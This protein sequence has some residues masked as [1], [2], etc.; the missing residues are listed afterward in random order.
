MIFLT[1]AFEILTLAARRRRLSFLFLAVAAALPLRAQ[2]T[3]KP[4]LIA[5]AADLKFALDEVLAEFRKAHPE[6]DPKPTYGSSGT[7][8]AQID[9]GAPFDLFLS[10]DVKFPR[11]LIE[12]A[13][14]EKDSLF[15]YAIG[16]VVVWVPKESKLDLT[17]LE[18]SMRQA[19]IDFEPRIVPATLRVEAIV[20]GQV[21]DHHNVVSVQI[22]CQLWGQTLPLELLL[23]TEVDLETGTVE[24]RDLGRS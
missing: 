14:A 21:L 1:S 3:P 10:A 18:T 9:N 13:K 24:I 12:R 8:F 23:R 4:L 16:H 5:A 6:Y 11:Q 15:F 2:D 22:T 19:I 20:T 17:A 7:L